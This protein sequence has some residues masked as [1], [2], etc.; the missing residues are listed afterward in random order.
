MTVA[1]RCLILPMSCSPFQRGVL[2]L[3]Q[4]ESVRDC[5]PGSGASHSGW[6]KSK[7]VSAFTQGDG[8]MVH[9]GCQGR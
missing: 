2:E 4:E 9:G 6:G 3:L 8:H 7:I 5:Q 1:L